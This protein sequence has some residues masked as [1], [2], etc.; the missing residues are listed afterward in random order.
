MAPT[1]V[2]IA[3]MVGELRRLDNCE[4]YPEAGFPSVPRTLPSDLTE[5]Y[6]LTGG[7]M[8]FKG[9]DYSI[10]VVPPKS[11]FARIL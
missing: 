3:E 8:L 10:E 2:E 7:A 4:V 5:F 9:Q 1:N 11:S 6:G